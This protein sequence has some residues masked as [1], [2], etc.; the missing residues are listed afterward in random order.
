MK[1]KKGMWCVPVIVAAFFLLFGTSIGAD[2]SQKY[3]KNFKVFEPAKPFLDPDIQIKPEFVEGKGARIG[4]IQKIQGK[5]YVIHKGEKVA[6]LL[7]KK[8]PLFTGDTLITEKR[9]RVNAAMNDK[10]VFALAPLSKLVIDKSVYDAEKNTRNSLMVTVHSPLPS[11]G[12]G[13]INS[14]G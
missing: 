13:L 6:Y 8:L 11:F 2:N 9:S 4:H 7:K 1:C 3:L 5:V 12:W 14:M 10:S